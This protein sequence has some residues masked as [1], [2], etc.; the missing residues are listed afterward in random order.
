VRSRA[1]V[2]GTE[3]S[4]ALSRIPKTGFGSI[5]N[6]P[7]SE[8]IRSRTFRTTDANVTVEFKY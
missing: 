2:K 3:R 7:E 1:K 8:R 4:R 6:A 5:S